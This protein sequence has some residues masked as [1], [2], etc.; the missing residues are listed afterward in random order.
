MGER[1]TAARRSGRRGALLTGV[2][3]LALTVSACQG[4]DSPTVNTPAPVN[5]SKQ[6]AAQK[7]ARPALA[8]FYEQKLHWTKCKSNFCTHLTVP[9]DYAKPDGATIKIAVLKVPARKQSQR[10]GSLV[11]N[12]GGPGGSGVTYATYADNIVGAG[13]RDVYDVVGFDPRGVGA[14]APITC[15]DNR[16]LDTYLGGDPTPDDLAEEKQTVAAAKGFAA[17]CKANGGPLLGHVSTVEAAKDMDVLRAAL[18]DTKLTYLGKSYGTFLGATYAGLFPTKVGRFV[19]DGV[20]PPNLT[21]TQINAGQAEGFETATR[22]YVADCVKSGD[23][24]LGQDLDAGMQRLRDFL[25]QLDAQPI[26]VTGDADVTEL[27]EGW[28][29]MGVASAMYDQRLWPGLTD[30]LRDAFAGDGSALMALANQYADRNADGTFNDNIMQVI[31]AVNCLDRSDSNKIS[32][33]EQDA[34]AFSVKSPTWGAFLAWGSV[35]CGFW[36]F[37]AT[38]HPEKISAKGS[39]PIMVIGTTR[40]PATPYEWSKILADQ[41][42]NGHLVTFNGDGHTAYMRSNSCLDGTVDAYLL[43]GTVPPDGKRC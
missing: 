43:K 19:L 28:G 13:I 42:A 36:P 39:G 7:P 40:D 16:Q 23:C 12:P 1:H 4:L 34:K 33:Y 10:L 15:M 41:L 18:G 25:K 20:V 22:A 11:V 29:S 9:I 6:A 5:P 27:T 30:A 31:Y 35:P 24:P 21:S 14:S 38:G 3:A 32:V 2:F 26:K 8:T 17:D 37:P